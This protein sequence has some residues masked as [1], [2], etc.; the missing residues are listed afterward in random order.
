MQETEGCELGGV[1]GGV[2]HGVVVGW[3]GET[4]RGVAM[5]D[6]WLRHSSAAGII[7]THSWHTAGPSLA[8]TLLNTGYL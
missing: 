1:R 8:A 2:G 4:R 5:V 7:Q 6:G 3:E